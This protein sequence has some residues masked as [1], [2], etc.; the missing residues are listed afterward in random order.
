[1]KPKKCILSWDKYIHGSSDALAFRNAVRQAMD[2][3][4]ADFSGELEQGLKQLA[5]TGEAA[6]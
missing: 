5:G 6:Q 2:A 4:K 3:A 1:M